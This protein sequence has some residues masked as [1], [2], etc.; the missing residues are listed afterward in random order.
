MQLHVILRTVFVYVIFL[1][2]WLVSTLTQLGKHENIIAALV[3]GFW[4]NLAF[5]L[6]LLLCLWLPPAFRISSG[7]CRLD[8]VPLV[9]HPTIC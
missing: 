9:D 2:L 6:V 4:G 7:L 8:L 3:A 1:V 5:Y